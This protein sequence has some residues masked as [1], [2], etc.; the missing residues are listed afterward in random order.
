MILLVS[1]KKMFAAIAIVIIGVSFFMLF[2][3]ET[4]SS[5]TT[6][7]KK[8]YREVSLIVR[9]IEFR[10]GNKYYSYVLLNVSAAGCIVITN[11]KRRT[12]LPALHR[13]ETISPKLPIRILPNESFPINITLYDDDLSYYLPKDNY[14]SPNLIIN[15]LLKAVNKYHMTPPIIKIFYKECGD[16]TYKMKEINLLKYIIKYIK[17]RY[18][19]PYDYDIVEFDANGGEVRYGKVQN[20][21]ELKFR[22]FSN[23]TI[24]IDRLIFLVVNKKNHRVALNYTYYVSLTLPPNTT[25]TLR[26]IVPTPP[27]LWDYYMVVYSYTREGVVRRAGT[28]L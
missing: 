7:Q 18:W 4:F 23:Y 12:P 3:K 25:K 19:T 11:I 21:V 10:P 6:P 16:N 17:K 20:E 1:R 28:E 13:I 15:G 22:S 9:R 24:H 8:F 27:R 2:W 14:T 5:T 26:L